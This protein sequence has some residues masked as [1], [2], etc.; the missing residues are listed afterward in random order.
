MATVRHDGATTLRRRADVAAGHLGRAASRF[1]RSSRRCCRS[2]SCARACWRSSRRSPPSPARW[3]SPRSA[4]LLAF[5]AFVVIWREG[6][7]GLGSAILA[8]V[9][10]AAAARLSGLS[11]LPRHQAAGDHRHHHRP[12]R[13][14]ALRRAGAVAAARHATTMPGCDAAE[15][16][17]AAYPDIEPLQVDRAAARSPIDVALALVDQAQMARGRCP[18]RRRRRAATA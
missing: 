17:R 10:R 6:L 18:R 12:A 16:Q 15:L 4:I 1:S 13:S 8:I 9:P 11:R 2:S 5:G 14:A 7:T 3:S